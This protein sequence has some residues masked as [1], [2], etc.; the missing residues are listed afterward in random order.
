[1]ANINFKDYPAHTSG[2]LPKVGA[3]APNFNLVKNDLSQASLES[4]AG[5]NKILNIFPSIDTGVCASSVRKFNAESFKAPNTVVLNVS[6]DLPFAQKRFCGAEGITNVE[7]LSGFRS[8]FGKD[9]GL[10]MIDTPLAGL[11]SRVVVV[12][13]PD[14]KVLYTEQVDEIG[15]EPSYEAALNSIR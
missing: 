6:M 9:Y 1:M 3:K 11:Y 15:N 2:E 7:T 10:I 4:F 8:S 5:K 14:D 12:I 13:S